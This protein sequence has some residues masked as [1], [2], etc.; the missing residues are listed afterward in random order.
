M[1]T[2]PK[3]KNDQFHSGR[4]SVLNAIADDPYCPVLL[5]KRFF[6]RF[7]LQFGHQA[8]DTTF[9]NFQL[10]KSAGQ[11][12]PICHKSLSS[13]GA[14][15]SLRKTFQAAGCPIHKVTDKSVKMAGVT[16]A[17]AAG[18]TTEDVM[19]AGRWQSQE[20]PLRYKL[21]SFE[22]KKYVASKIPRIS[23]I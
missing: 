18:A 11:W 10:R 15:D 7:S 21:N 9:V 3:A 13:S 12:F 6:Q 8:A 22:F 2:F 1:I 20:T 19:H 5:V 4:F 14:T 23:D 16:A 17:F